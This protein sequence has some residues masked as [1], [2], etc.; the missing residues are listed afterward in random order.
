MSVFCVY[1]VVWL[2]AGVAVLLCSRVC[3]CVWLC[4]CSVAGLSDCVC[5][6]ACVCL[7]G[8]GFSCVCGG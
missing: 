8:G 1:V 4:G 5:V 2:L 7:C 3:V 6:L